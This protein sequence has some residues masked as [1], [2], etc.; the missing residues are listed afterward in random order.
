MANRYLINPANLPAAR[1]V[2]FYP[3]ADD[4]LTRGY[5]STLQ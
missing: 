2:P 3:P 5:R 1:T 4:R